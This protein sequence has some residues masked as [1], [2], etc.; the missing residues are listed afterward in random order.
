[1]SIARD[2][3]APQA[4]GL[5]FR[6]LGFAVS[7]PWNALIA[8]AVIALLWY[9]EF[10]GVGSRAVQLVTAALFAVLLMGSILLHELA[11]GLAARAFRYPVVGITLWAMG[12]FTTYRTTKRHGPAREAAI[13]L[14]GPITTLAVALGAYAVAGLAPS[15]QVSALFQALGSA[16]LLIGIFNLL[17]GSPLDGGAVVK[18]AVWAV[19]GS[20][21]SGQVV[22]GW[23]G[24]GLAVVVLALPLLV[25]WRSGGQ[26]SLIGLVVGV[27]LAALLWTGATGSLRAAQ[28]ARSLAGISAARISQVV[29]VIPATASVASA[30]ALARPGVGLVAMDEQGRPVGVVSPEA[31]R[32]VPPEQAADLPVLTVS[33]S[34]AEELPVVSADATAR[35]VLD[36]C[37]R[38]GSRF[39]LVA[40]TPL[41]LVDTDSAFVTEGA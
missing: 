10:L 3:A 25:A 21:E 39:V 38:T 23:V 22:A 28:A 35:E 41:R 26:P 14:A 29:D 37:Q 7:V 13:A 8:I 6:L 30:V 24:R 16:N 15:E 1:M 32:A 31:A 17:P 27:M 9:P 12:G 18:S 40:G 2:A 4:S 5:R 20:Q 11:H 34:V 33:A 19:T 36:E